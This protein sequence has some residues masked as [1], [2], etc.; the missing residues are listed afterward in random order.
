MTT[1]LDLVADT[2]RQVYG[3][4][5]E[6]LNL[7]ASPAAAGATSLTMSMDVTGI[8]PG[9]IISSGLNVW[10]VQGADANSKTVYVVP[11]FD[12]SPQQAVNTGDMVYIHPRVTSWYL[13]TQ[14]N[15]EIRRLSSPELGLYKIASWEDQVDPTW[16]TYD[17]PESAQ[18]LTGILRVRYLIP[19]TPDMWID[20][21][22]KSYR[23]QINDGA[24]RIRLLR[25]IPS[26]TRVQFLY[27]APFTEATSLADDLVDDCGLAETMTDIPSLG[28]A[29]RLLR[30][31]ETQRGQITSQGDT[32]R[33][34]E[35]P[36]SA[37]LQSSQLLERDYQRR[38]QEELGRLIAR[39]SVRRSL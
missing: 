26:G 7:I 10:W 9:K 20:L 8:T 35:V 5:S 21:P 39:V 3:T 4:L 27:K 25:H 11:G 13:F 17:I 22:D 12:N 18:N 31:T 1:M 2:R 15:R 14:I 16:Q 30:T 32:R 19:G 24:S 36:T 23:L 29:F 6:Q 28:A 38:V 37:N 33:P 34:T